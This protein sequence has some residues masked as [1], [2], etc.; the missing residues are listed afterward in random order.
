MESKIN[1]VNGNKK[2]KDK[3][4][5]GVKQNTKYLPVY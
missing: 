2:N 5:K 3:F 4:C 1:D